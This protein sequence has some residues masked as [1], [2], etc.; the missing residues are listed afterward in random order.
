MLAGDELSPASNEDGAT[1]VSERE[2]SASEVSLTGSNGVSGGGGVGDVSN[3]RKLEIRNVGLTSYDDGLELQRKTAADRIKGKH[4]IEGGIAHDV[5]ILCEHPP[6]VTLGRSTKAGN[7]LVTAEYL[8]AVGVELREVERGGD[9]TIHEP[10]QLVIYPIVDLEQHRKDLHWYLRQL[11]EVVIVAL[12]ENGIEGGRV[13]GLTG[14]WVENRKIASIGV[15]AR[16]WVTWH[17]VALN[18]VND[19]STFSHVVPCGIDGVTM[20]T[21]EREVASGG[22]SDVLGKMQSGETMMSMVLREVSR[23]FVQV[24]G[25][26]E[27]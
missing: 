27:Y 17:G 20:T 16:D 9:V 24:F 12:K 18:V 14:V 13:T 15:H 1:V 26:N 21:V 25:F 3:V 2:V 22:L 23:S 4:G 8:S 19:L 7:L 10:G 5:L 6:V 11:E